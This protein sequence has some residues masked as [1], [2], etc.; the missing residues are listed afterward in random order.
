MRGGFA[1][2]R[3][4]EIAM[5]AGI[6]EALIYRHFSSKEELFEA[7]VIEPLEHWMSNY[8]HIGGLVAKTTEPETQLELMT[9]T[10][11]EYLAQ[12]NA[13][14]PLLGIALFGNHE[15]GREFYVKRMV[16]MINRWAELTRKSLA[17][18]TRG[19]RLD[20]YFLSR[21]GLGL[22]FFLTA[23][24]RFRGVKIDEPQLARQIA[25]LMLPMFE[26]KDVD[27][28]PAYDAKANNRKARKLA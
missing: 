21:A 14:L 26:R 13:I 16:P 18:D 17:K 25:Q 11:T 19:A 20:P 15:H 7:A 3:T 22:S 27:D 5:E 2:A 23:D 24:A 9:G 8:H 10:L 6:N 4:K 1:G 12:I 28:S